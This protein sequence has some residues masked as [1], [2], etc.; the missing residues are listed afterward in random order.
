M[1]TV[2]Y[3]YFSSLKILLIQVQSTVK[4]PQLTPQNIF[5]SLAVFFLLSLSYRHF[6]ATVNLTYSF[7]FVASF[8][9]G[10][11]APSTTQHAHDLSEDEKE[12]F[13]KD[14]KQPSGS[15]QPP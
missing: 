2:Q 12:T 3:I 11:T 13:K 4:E 8:L 14:A 15:K 9:I 5:I 7:L 6:A 1:A 10:A